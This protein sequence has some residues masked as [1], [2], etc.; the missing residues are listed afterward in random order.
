MGTSPA[1]CGCSGCS[2]VMSACKNP[3]QIRPLKTVWTFV[4][5]TI[6]E[7]RSPEAILLRESQSSKSLACELRASGP[8][9]GSFQ[10]KPKR[11]T[12]NCSA[13][14]CL[15]NLMSKGVNGL[16]EC[17]AGHRAYSLWRFTRM[18]TLLLCPAVCLW[19]W[20]SCA[21][22]WENFVVPGQQGVALLC[23]YPDDG[24][25]WW[26]EISWSQNSVSDCDEGDSMP[27]KLPLEP[28]CSLRWLWHGDGGRGG[29][30]GRLVLSFNS[31]WF[32]F[33][34][35][36]LRK[37]LR[38]SVCHQF[39]I[40]LWQNCSQAQSKV[41]LSSLC[42]KTRRCG[43]RPEAEGRTELP[44][45]AVVRYCGRMQNWKLICKF[46]ISKYLSQCRGQGWLRVCVSQCGANTLI[47]TIKVKIKQT[48]M[49][50]VKAQEVLEDRPLISQQG[51]VLSL[52]RPLGQL[53][54]G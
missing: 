37:F 13:F 9:L 46:Q 33:Y 29:R 45:L 23:R 43:S 54:I 48:N 21:S 20:G 35:N 3:T 11:T 10:S 50:T 19:S 44:G 1:G 15:H 31:A 30:K 4:A 12:L 39:H 34:R 6:L 41:F 51:W 25:L 26:D 53:L 27:H 5:R 24:G 52:G 40:H 2:P 47:N 18:Y 32:I 7:Q 22:V 28:E 38:E 36:P 16:Q 14:V 8:S 17:Q 49:L 42:L